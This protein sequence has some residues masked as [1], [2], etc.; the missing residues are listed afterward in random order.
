[1]SGIEIVMI[2]SDFYL[3]LYE[4]VDEHPFKDKFTAEEAEENAWFTIRDVLD[5]YMIDGLIEYKD[6]EYKFTNKGKERYESERA[7]EV[8]ADE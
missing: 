7:L 4:W 6:G 8:L 1:M 2:F 3:N 5:F